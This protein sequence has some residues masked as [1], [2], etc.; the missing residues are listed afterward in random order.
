MICSTDIA[1]AVPAR[2]L[3]AFRRGEF[4]RRCKMAIV[5]MLK[6]LVLTWTMKIPVPIRMMKIPVLMWMT[7]ALASSH[8]CR[9]ALQG[10]LR[11]YFSF[12]SPLVRRFSSTFA[13]SV[14][15]HAR[16]L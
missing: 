15:F 12:P 10:A 9:T 8:M 3:Y 7:D 13:D 2:Y 14:V 6:V 16:R 1:Q 5:A 11:H 4:V